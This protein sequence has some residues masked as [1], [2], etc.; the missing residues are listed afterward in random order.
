[1]R[2]QTTNTPPVWRWRTRRI[3][4]AAVAGA[5]YAALTMLLYP[6]SYGPLQ[7][8]LSEA[9]CILPFFD[10]IFAPGLFVGCLIANLISA[11]GPLDVVFGSLATLLA[12]LAT[13]AC[14]RRSRSFMSCVLGC[15]A[16]V[17]SNGLI[18]GAV[19]AA[20]VAPAG[21]AFEAAWLLY[22][23][24]VA[25]GEAV[26]LGA[27]GLPLARVLQKREIMTKILH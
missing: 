27:V 23:G 17:V 9:L 19:L 6:I 11:S 18:V 25:L 5:A 3:A 1:M 22:G 16:P 24:E 26:V 10:P 7:F 4:V 14:G 8:R 13:A 2:K 12:A 15:L 20:T 21:K